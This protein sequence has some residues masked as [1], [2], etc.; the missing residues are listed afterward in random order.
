MMVGIEVRWWGILG[1][2]LAAAPGSED[3]LALARSVTRDS[4]GQPAVRH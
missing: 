2:E 1:E 3:S 4:A